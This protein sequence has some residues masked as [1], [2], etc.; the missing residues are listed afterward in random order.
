M[1][2]SQKISLKVGGSCIVIDG[3]SITIA[4]MQVKINSGG[5]GT[6]TGDPVI[7]DPLDAESAD[8]G[9]PGYLDRPRTGGGRRGRNRRQLRSQHHVYPPRPGED[10]RMTQFRNTLN[11]SAAGRHALEVYERYGIQTRFDSSDGYYYDPS[12]NTMTMNPTMDQ[13]FQTTGFVHE[14]SHGQDHNEGRE[15]D[16]NSLSRA[17][18]IDQSLQNEA[19]GDALANQARRELEANGHNMGATPT[20]SQAAYDRGYNQAVAA[21][22]AANPDATPEELEEAG[23]RGGEAEILSEYRAGRVQTSTPG[24]PSYPT[25]YGNAWD[26]AHPPAGGGTP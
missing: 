26:A 22:Q 7:D 15:V 18:Y 20:Q 2:A 11:D 19:H 14:M 21:E 3:S 17:D 25:Y 24:N 10:A 12:T 4:A 1:E 6:E 23:R 5:Y 13:G 8:T 16:I 9:E